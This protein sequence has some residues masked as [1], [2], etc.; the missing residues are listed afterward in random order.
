MAQTKRYTA[1]K[2]LRLDCGHTIKAGETFVVTSI[3]SCEKDADWPLGVL[4][5]AFEKAL[6]SLMAELKQVSVKHEGEQPK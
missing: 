5:A 1:K 6:S 2:D 4:R 3:Y